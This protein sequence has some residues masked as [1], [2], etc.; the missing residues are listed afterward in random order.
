MEGLLIIIGLALLGNLFVRPEATIILI[1]L[2]IG[3]IFAIKMIIWF[4]TYCDDSVNQHR[5]DK[6]QKVIGEINKLI[7]IK[8]QDIETIEKKLKEYKRIQR[9]ISLLNKCNSSNAAP[10][11]YYT[12]NCVVLSDNKK[13]TNME[14]QDLVAL[15]ETLKKEKADLYSDKDILNKYS[16]QEDTLFKKYCSYVYRRMYK[17]V[18]LSI[19]IMLLIVVS[20]FGLRVGIKE[21]KYQRAGKLTSKEKYEEAYDIYESIQD[22]KDSSDKQESLN[23]M[24]YEQARS[25]ADND[26]L[27]AAL[28]YGRLATREYKDSKKRSMSCW[29]KYYYHDELK[30]QEWF[31]LAIDNGKT[32]VAPK[33][34]GLDTQEWE[35]LVS[36]DIGSGSRD[37][38]CVGLKSNGRVVTT[39]FTKS[40]RV[41]TW[42]YY[43]DYGKQ[44]ENENIVDIGAGYN[45]VAGLQCDGMIK[46]VGDRI[47][48]GA[49]SAVSE[50]KDIIEVQ[51]DNEAIVALDKQGVLHTV[52]GFSDINNKKDVERYSIENGEYIILYK[53][54]QIKSSQKE[55]E[56]WNN[57]IEVS[58]GDHFVLGLTEDGNVLAAG[59][60][61]DGQCEVSE[62]REVLHVYAGYNHSVALK[63]DGTYL[64][65]GKDS[66]TQDELTGY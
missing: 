25:M 6:K 47:S 51:V 11:R 1:L 10:L 53:D 13:R 60:N 64:V 44:F 57:I 9:I 26:Y 14:I 36:I 19:S 37:T 65:V 63:K 22:Y 58:A 17:N 18:A 20:F 54:G 61:S 40:S 39:G 2:I 16:Y 21:Y 48:E 29:K 52:G 49:E 55:A 42:S 59:N 12:K 56:S 50:W 34:T 66:Y 24:I 4:L 35:N 5:E 8:N 28:M 23:P 27:Q 15:K 31:V 46:L 43:G 62:W 30:P 45:M 38:E 3:I 41:T 32:I 33:D 7:N